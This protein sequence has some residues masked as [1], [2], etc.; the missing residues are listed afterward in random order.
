MKGT[1]FERVG[2]E[3]VNLVIKKG[4]FVA[5]IGHTGSGKSTLIQHFNGLI[6]PDSGRVL[7]NGT[8]VTNNNLTQVRRTVGIVFQYPEHQIFEDTVYKD[9]TFGLRNAGVGQDETNL[10][11]QRALELFNLDND[12]LNR[13]P[14]ELSDGEKRKVAILGVTIMDPDILILDEPTVGLDVKDRENLFD[15]ILKLFNT[16]K[17]TVIF[18][19]HSIEHVIKYAERVIIMNKGKIQLDTQVNEIFQQD[20][21]LQELNILTPQIHKFMKEL[22]KFLPSIDDKIF[23]VQQA[24][25]EILREY[26]QRSL[27]GA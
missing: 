15:F 8:E 7:I 27:Y 24:K 23:T 5:L 3:N 10:K 4:E 9:I 19:T 18:I 17:V 13:S 11:L 26:F 2:L 12:I 21:K 22:K 14:F 1:P 6:L 16:R 20:L 25:K